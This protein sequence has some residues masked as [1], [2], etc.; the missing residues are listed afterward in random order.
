MDDRKKKITDGKMADDRR[1]LPIVWLV[2]FVPGFITLFHICC[3]THFNVF[4]ANHQN[5]KS[6]SPFVFHK[7]NTIKR[8]LSG[9]SGLTQIKKDVE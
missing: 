6:P 7:W 5:T 2:Y 8:R 1:K 4:I 3:V 9:L